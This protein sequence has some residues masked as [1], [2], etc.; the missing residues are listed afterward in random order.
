MRLANWPMKIDLRN[1][2]LLGT[3]NAL[4]II[5]GSLERRGQDPALYHNHLLK[6]SCSRMDFSR[7]FPKNE[8][9]LLDVTLKHSGNT[10]IQA[11]PYQHRVQI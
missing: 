2:L 11:L 7:Q 10:I 3:R 6:Y 8:N 5:V 4:F 9:T 1:T